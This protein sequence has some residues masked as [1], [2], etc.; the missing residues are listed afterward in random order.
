MLYGL[1]RLLRGLVKKFQAEM[2]HTKRQEPCYVVGAGLCSGIENGIAAAD[3]GLD[4]MIRPDAIAEP[5][6]MFVTR[7]AAI[8]KIC[9]VGQEGAENAML[10]MKH[11]HVLMD[12]YLEPIRWR[13]LQQ[14]FQLR[15]IQVI[16]SRDALQS[17]VGL[18]VFRRQM[19]SYVQRIITDSPV[20][21]EEPQ[22]IIVPHEI[23]VGLT[24]TN[25]FECPFLAHFEN[26]R[27]S[28]ENGGIVC[29]E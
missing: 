5:N 19:I 1:H 11:R 9:A 25:L 20:S 7:P 29:A 13:R 18:E 27:R 8:G 15:E 24:R 23:A 17:K 21:S 22:M 3:I 14:R 4:W 2:S 6:V 10:H 26:S 16:G 12:G 28:H